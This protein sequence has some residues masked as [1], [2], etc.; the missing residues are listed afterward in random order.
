M[1]H[2]DARDRRLGRVR[3]RLLLMPDRPGL[4]ADMPL[5]GNVICYVL[6]ARSDDYPE[7]VRNGPE[8][9]ALALAHVLAIDLERDRPVGPDRQP[10]LVV[11]ADQV[12]PAG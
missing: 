7:C 9:N 3:R 4:A 6:S 11:H 8:C 10:G 12:P 1:N 5:S 2:N